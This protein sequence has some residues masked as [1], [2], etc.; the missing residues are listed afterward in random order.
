MIDEAWLP[1]PEERFEQ[2]Q[3]TA[4]IIREAGYEAI[5]LDH[6]AKPDD[7]LATAARQG[8]STGIF[9]AI[10]RMPAAG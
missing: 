1:G 3:E 9:R 7:P 6:F 4:R 2:Q 10:P 5:G 8:R